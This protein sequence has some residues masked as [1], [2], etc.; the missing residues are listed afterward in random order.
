MQKIG[1]I[2]ILPPAVYNLLA[3][4]EVVENPAAVVKECVENSLDAGAMRIEIAIE[5]GGLDLIRVTDNGSGVDAGEIDKVFLPHATSKIAS[6]GDLESIA[7][8]G[9]RGEALSSI[10]A[11]SQVEFVTKTKNAKT[12][13]KFPPKVSVA[14]NVGT[15]VTVKNL[16]YNTPARKKFLRPP[17]VEKNNVTGVV[18]KLILANP[19]VAFRY[20]IDG[21]VVYDYRGKTLLDAIQAVYGDEA[22]QSLIELNQRSP[23][24][25]GGGG[26]AGGGFCIR[27]FISKPFFTKRNRTHQVL[28]VNGRA[29]EPDTIGDTVN[30]VFENYMVTRNYPFF[31]LCL[32]IDTREIDVNVHPRKAQVK[33]SHEA[34][35]CDFVRLAVTEAVDA[36]LMDQ[37]KNHFSPQQDTEILQRIKHFASNSGN[38]ITAVKSADHTMNLFDLREEAAREAVAV[39]AA[40]KQTEMPQAKSGF[41]TL[42]AIFDTYILVKAGDTFHII[43]QHAAHERL[44]YDELKKQVDAGAVAVQRLLDPGV[45]VLSAEEMTKMDSA[46]PYLNAMGIECAPFGT[47]CF[48]ITA[49]PVVV[50]E[51]G[52]ETVIENMLYDVKST[53]PDKLSTILQD[54]IIMQCCRNAIKAGQSLSDVQIKYFMDQISM[55]NSRPTC[56]HGRPVVISYSRDQM[57]KLFARK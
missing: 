43:D 28:V 5:R 13:T 37:H 56:P 53:P 25:K 57:A 33:F 44:L 54:K 12:A 24:H 22:A 41:V 6:A 27:G 55:T 8:L 10:A 46:A 19:G 23:L 26:E 36:Y 52:V 1:K 17:H 29:V 35:L 51:H 38:T 4:G 15:T 40:P 3:A 16:F 49:L 20:S 11:V 50:A 31:V 18:Q 32:D 2:N 45:M 21:E 47:N 34:E 7:T 30:M 39:K 9:F 14:G 48:R 42:G